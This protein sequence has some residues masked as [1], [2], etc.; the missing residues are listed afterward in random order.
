MP[1][2][3]SSLANDSGDWE[4][5]SWVVQCMYLYHRCAACVSSQRYM[6]PSSASIYNSSILICTSAVF[7]FKLISPN[8]AW[9]QM[10]GTS[11]N[12]HQSL[13]VCSTK[14]AF[15]L[16]TNYVNCCNM[17]DLTVAM[18]LL[19][20]GLKY[21]IMLYF[22]ACVVMKKADIQDIRERGMILSL[23][24]TGLMWNTFHILTLNIWDYLLSFLISKCRCAGRS[25]KS[26]SSTAH[27]Q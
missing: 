25:L 23:Y 18:S 27:L 14:R 5:G 26:T 13:N 7:F 11:L 24:D 16:Q 12:Q 10:W 3:S 20:L 22:R 8:A 1:S 4:K 21:F 19:L 9:F 6:H 15:L 2:H 17:A